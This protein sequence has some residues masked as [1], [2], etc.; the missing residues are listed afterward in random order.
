MKRIGL[1][2]SAIVLFLCFTSCK[3]EIEIRFSKTSLHF[4]YNG[5]SQ[6][7]ELISNGDWSVTSVPEWVDLSASSGSGNT[8][9]TVTVQR[10][11]TLESM[12][13]I[14][15]FRTKDN[16]ASFTIMQDFL[17]E[18][19]LDVAPSSIQVGPEGDDVEVSISSSGSWYLGEMPYWI[20]AS[21]TSGDGDANITITV[22]SCEGEEQ[23]YRSAVIPVV[24]GDLSADLSVIQF[25]M[26]DDIITINP[27]TQ[28]VSY[29][30]GEFSITVISSS[31]W[32]VEPADW[33]VFSVTEGEGITTIEV[34]V[35]ENT[36]I[37]E[38]MAEISFI[39]GDMVS[40]FRLSQAA[41]PDSHYLEVSSLQL[42]FPKQGGTMPIGVS[43]NAEWTAQC[44]A[45]WI[46]LSLSEGEGDGRFDVEVEPNEYTGTR[47]ASILVV[48]GSKQARIR[49]TQ[50]S[51]SIEPYFE[52]NP[53]TIVFDYE[54]GT[55]TISVN[56][57]VDW[58]L[59]G[60]P[61]V[62][63]SI[64][65]GHGDAEIVLTAGQNPSQ[66]TVT[67]EMAF[68]ANGISTMVTVV[69]R[70]PGVIVPIL[71]VDVT[72]INAP[73]EG[74][75]YTINITSNQ[76]W[77]VSSASWVVVTP[78]SGENNGV[79]TVKVTE[80]PIALPRT[81]EIKVSCASLTCII[82]VNQS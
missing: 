54:G 47:T 56:S 12:N 60:L 62:E 38:R 53:T 74:G 80:N 70:G 37:V 36:E 42:E 58:F 82:R 13:G 41:A 59:K 44:V 76:Q 75:A 4:A 15:E 21:E 64:T 17:S 6:T 9:L 65:E 73:S 3:E 24:S 14:V 66:T 32:V 2:L 81:S 77:S 22:V 35:S 52:V 30:G 29:E 55:N 33:T 25:C 5:G 40:V 49:V 45:S 1:F 69:Q 48:S 71:E 50:E 78:E 23:L 18:A 39:A 27:P 67:E 68:E 51:G 72:E 7:I 46:T 28:L 16:T 34:T 10:N 57:N 20:Q 79:L 61:W 19:F 8:T 31:P 43:C 63:A 26:D 11:A